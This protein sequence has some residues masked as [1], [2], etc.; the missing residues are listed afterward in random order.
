MNEHYFKDLPRSQ[1][2]EELEANAAKITEMTYMKQFTQEELG[3]EKDS[4]V[5]SSIELARLE[6]EKK[7]VIED[8]KTKIDPHKKAIKAR[9][10]NIK[11][12]QREVTEQVYMLAEH[13]EGF[14][15]TYNEDGDLI[16]KRRLRQD[17]RQTTMKL[18][19]GTHN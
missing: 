13:H 9:I 6:D 14:M 16:E 19:T 4:L 10:Q 15:Y 12:G 17:E 2:L 11:S 3:D 5:E 8:F 18:S 1:R 7:V